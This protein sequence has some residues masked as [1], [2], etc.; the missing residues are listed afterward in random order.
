MSGGLIAVASGWLA[1]LAVAPRD[2][3]LAL[4]LVWPALLGAA[5]LAFGE[6]LAFRG[7]ALAEPVR[8]VGMAAAAAAG[9]LA[10]GQA[11][12]RRE[13]GLLNGV[14]VPVAAFGLAMEGETLLVPG[15]LAVLAAGVGIAIGG[16]GWVALAALGVAAVGGALGQPGM[17]TLA[18]ATLVVGEASA[19]AWPRFSR[20]AG[21]LF[22]TIALLPVLAV[23]P[24]WVL[25]AVA[26]GLGL[27]AWRGLR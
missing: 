21:V 11:V 20:G 7:A 2:R 17:G 4:R 19:I 14:V 9:P 24:G 12:A 25:A 13:A 10:L 8:A 26:S 22:A 5:L 6:A 23:A 27:L 16:A 15:A 3:G 18:G 1:V